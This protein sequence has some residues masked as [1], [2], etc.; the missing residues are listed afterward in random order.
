MINIASILGWGGMVLIVVAYYLLSTK[1]INPH[2]LGYGLMN[3][4]GG[5]GV[6]LNSFVNKAWPTLTLNVLW[7][8]IA[9]ISIMKIKK[10][11]K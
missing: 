6:S 1:R 3:L 9:L 5:L 11:K 7:A 10:N 4:F 8:L 2:S